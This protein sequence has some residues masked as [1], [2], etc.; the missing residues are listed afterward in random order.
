M[1]GEGCSDLQIYV[2]T[3]TPLWLDL[4]HCL[5]IVFQGLQCLLSRGPI[6]LVNVCCGDALPTD[7]FLAVCSYQYGYLT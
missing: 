3:S 6:D 1:F 2:R 7:G 4:L 5:T